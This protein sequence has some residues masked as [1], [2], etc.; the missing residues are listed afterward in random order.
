MC[1]SSCTPQTSVRDF[2]L[3]MVLKNPQWFCKRYLC[4]RTS[5]SLRTADRFAQSDEKESEQLMKQLAD[6]ISQ[7]DVDNAELIDLV[8]KLH[9]QLNSSKGKR[10][11]DT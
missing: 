11:T 10:Y 7:N 6:N 3:I 2:S 9:E 4:G 1:I 5:P 8:A